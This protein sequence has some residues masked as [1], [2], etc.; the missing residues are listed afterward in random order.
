MSLILSRLAYDHSL[1]FV[2]TSIVICLVAGWL[3]ARLMRNVHDAKPGARWRWMAGVAVV[4]GLG[5]WTTHFIAMLGYRSD[6]MLGYGSGTTALSA[7]VAVLLVGGPLALVR[8][9]S[10]W[11]WRAGLGA[12][13][14]MGIGA[15]H[16]AGMAAIEGCLQTYSPL[17]SAVAT[18]VGGG[19]L[20]LACGLPSRL[21]GTRAVCALFTVAVGG[22]HFIAIA[23]TSLEPVG[24][25]GGLGGGH[26]ALSVFTAAGAA[27]LFLGAFLTIL[28]AQRFD[29]QER[30]HSTVLK[31]A[32]DNMS[33]GLLYL[34]EGDRVRLYNRRYL[35]IYGFEDGTDLIGMTADEIV[36]LVG[37]RHGWD[38]ERRVMARARLDSWHA[39]DRYT[40]IDYPLDDGRIMQVEI[41]PVA[42]GGTVITFDD[43]TGDRIAQRRIAELA[44]CDPLT[45]LANR[46]ALNERMERDFFPK[47]RFKLLLLDLD[48]FKPVNDTYGHAVG[49]RLLVQVAERLTRIAGADGFVAR[50]GGDEMALLVYDDHDAAMAIA[51][52]VIAAIA[53]P[54]Q[55]N[56]IAL[57]IGCSIGLCCTDDAR[58]AVELLQF[59]DIALYESKRQG[60]GRASCYTPGM[61]EAVSERVQ[62]EADMRTA[63]ERGEMHLAYQPV[64]AFS[65]D[66]IIGYEALIRWD[67]PKL[68]PVAPSRFIPLAEETGQIVAI[69]AWV[70]QEACRQIAELDA[71]V[72][73]AVNVSP[74]QFRSPLLLSHL[75]QALARSGLPARRLEIELTETA[76]VEDG[77]QMAEMLSAVR[78]LGVTVAMDDFGTGYSSFAHLRDFPL[79]RIKVD[80]SF[81][82]KAA[83]DRHAMAV[84]DGITHIARTLGVT[85]L[86]EGVET[87]EQL[88][89]LR[90]IGCDAVQGYLIG[91]PE[92]LS[93]AQPSISGSGLLSRGRNGTAADR[94]AGGEKVVARAS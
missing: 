37:D 31:T 79:D 66:R 50:L 32:L 49:D 6:L 2:V 82:A 36:D 57:S 15:M 40:S 34:D 48:R 9:L 64:V 25:P 7:L 56:G 54:F 5:V 71:D 80:R 4:A 35:E 43:V 22:T 78:R 28:T 47:Q 27:I 10:S 83:T 85:T 23:G 61:L 51:T 92:R 42:E 8:L 1:G 33:N 84:L 38:P 70:L 90:E 74:V 39:V 87:P 77:A 68:G 3:V 29:A 45:K 21:A 67:H 17:A 14:G 12:V 75:T 20:A 81:V 94:V 72:Y 44:F 53:A 65:D 59:A 88:R 26:L 18:G 63:I 93:Q 11:H 24:L 16:Y 62:L 89:L 19:C 86:A 41:R 46:R 73:V 52:Q 58:D 60:R 30:A 13:A 91:R 76:I 55:I 69:G